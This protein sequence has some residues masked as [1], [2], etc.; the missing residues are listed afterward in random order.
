MFTDLAVEQPVSLAVF[1]CAVA[2]SPKLFNKGSELPLPTE[3]RLDTPLVT[4]VPPTTF[5]EIKR[6]CRWP[7]CS[8]PPCLAVPLAMLD[9]HSHSVST[10]GLPCSNPVYSS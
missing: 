10:H 2:M 9:H 7:P 4:L 6:S 1:G 3:I 5:S 8:L